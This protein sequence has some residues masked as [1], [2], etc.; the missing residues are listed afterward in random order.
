[1]HGDE[2]GEVRNSG[3]RFE[4]LVK[5]R[6]GFDFAKKFVERSF[7]QGVKAPHKVL[8]AFTGDG[9][10]DHGEAP[11]KGR[12]LAVGVEKLENLN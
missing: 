5:W 1:V 3:V 8:E 4:A 2:A 11:L 10:F 9:V 7:A 12:G 6:V